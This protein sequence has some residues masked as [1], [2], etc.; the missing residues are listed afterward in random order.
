MGNEMQ[1]SI[2][3]ITALVVA[4]AATL[5]TTGHAQ[6]TGAATMPSA[7]HMPTV[8]GVEAKPGAIVS[9][10][11]PTTTL[12]SDPKLAVHV[13]GTGK[14]CQYH[15]VVINTD[16]SKESYFPQTSKFPALVHAN[17]PLD[18]FA[19]GNYKVA[20]MAWGSDKASGIACQGGGEYTPFKIERPKIA[21]GADWPKIT[22]MVLTP[23]KSAAANTYRADESLAYAVKGSVDNLDPKNADKRCGWTVML[24]GNGQS[25]ALG[26]GTFF[27]M[28]MSASLAAFKPG[29]Y[30]VK[31][32]TTPGDDS[33]AKMSCLGFASKPIT[34]VAVPGQIRGLKL[35]AKGI[36]GDGKAFAQAIDNGV[37]DFFSP[38]T[39][40]VNAFVADNGVLKITP[41][42]DGPTCF[43]R[44]TT[45]INGGGGPMVVPQKHVPGATH[46]QPVQVYS[47]D[48][49]NVEVTV[50]AG[51]VEKT[52]GAC[53]G[54]VTKTIV[55]QD[56]PKLPVVV[57]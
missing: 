57:R 39:S 56:D 48:Q 36:H 26:N 25:V 49:T 30:T 34:I 43:Y 13:T 18:Q 16:T 22:D 41:I 3:R 45:H 38:F 20:A 35:E 27:N 47:A 24:E 9:I 29:N 31:A 12:V 2:F 32:H 33:L 8:S 7:G 55:V 21:V 23:G 6:T 53:E 5:C 54:S 51:D 1:T 17:L 46:K 52:L 50:D 19:H 11:V 28:P 40:L 15:L 37:L 42:I 4:V 44:V 10:M 14:L